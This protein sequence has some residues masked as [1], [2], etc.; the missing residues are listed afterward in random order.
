MAQYEVFSALCSDRAQ[1]TV[2]Q[3]LL[4]GGTPT[5]PERYLRLWRDAITTSVSAETAATLHGIRAVAVLQAPLAS[6]TGAK[7]S[8]VRRAAS[9]RA[10]TRRPN[11]SSRPWATASSF[12][13]DVMSGPSFS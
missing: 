8:W 2:V 6:V 11:A 7:S 10:R 4:V 3:T 5:T 12:H 13:P 1:R 9:R